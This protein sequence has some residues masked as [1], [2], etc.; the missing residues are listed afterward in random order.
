VHANES[1]LV[2]AVGRWDLTAIIVNV[3]VGAGILGLPAKTFALIGVYSVPAWVVCALVMG[4]VALC[5]AEVGSRFTQT[6]GPYLYAYTAFGPHVGFLVGWLSWV[7]RLFSFATVANLA[8][9]YAGGLAVPL[10]T[11]AFRL[12]A[13]AV[14]TIVLTLVVLTG[15]R[16]AALVNNLL[17][18][19]KLV[20]LVGFAAGGLLLTR[21]DHMAPPVATTVDEWRAAMMLMTFA[22]LGIESALITSGE[23]RN[24]RHD[25]PSALGMALLVIALLYV[26][27][28]IVCIGT[29]P[30]LAAAQRPVLDAAENMFGRVGGCVVEIGALV[31]ML[32]TLFAI[33]LTGSRL[34]FAFAER[35][36]LPAVFCAIHPRFGTPYGAIL[37]TGILSGALALS[38]SFLGALT[39]S[40]LT[41]LV[42]YATTCAALIVLRRR[43]FDSAVEAST[44]SGRASYR[45]PGGEIVAVVALIACVA[46]MTGISGDEVR[47]VSVIALV[48]AAVAMRRFHPKV[49]SGAG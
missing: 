36:Q 18:V 25:M 49:H 35:G 21:F 19:C 33:L 11:G 44:S 46:L 14:T 48:G 16:R 39:V 30:G 31:M 40:A 6:G 42:G 15:L 37:L 2:R 45:A 13:I 8:T 28:Q 32:G 47:T 38:S 10:A 22:F 3:V 5:F 23:A 12:A 43:D 34:P 7:S 24:P 20:V 1:G 4:L 41:R 26:S 17:T 27:I 9:S 29:V